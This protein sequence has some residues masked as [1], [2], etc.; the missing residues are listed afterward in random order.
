M[1]RL[2]ALTLLSLATLFA[3]AFA[4]SANP[5]RPGTVNYIEGQAALGGGC[6]QQD[7]HRNRR[8]RAGPADYD[9]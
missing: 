6:S 1:P 5:A 9:C 3:P 7:F 2:K 4:E 8:G